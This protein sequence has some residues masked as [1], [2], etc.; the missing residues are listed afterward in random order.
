MERLINVTTGAPGN[1]AEW[2][3][4]GRPCVPLGAYIL[5]VVLGILAP[6]AGVSGIML[7]IMAVDPPLWVDPFFLLLFALSSGISA[8]LLGFLWPTVSWKWGIWL[9]LPFI[10][11]AALV[12]VAGPASNPSLL[13]MIAYSL[14]I[15]SPPTLAGAFA[16]QR[17]ARRV[18]STGKEREGQSSDAQPVSA[19]PQQATNLPG[20][21]WP[22]T[23]LDREVE[24]TFLTER[25]FVAGQQVT[26][27]PFDD[28]PETRANNDSRKE[29]D[30]IPTQDQLFELFSQFQSP[31]PKH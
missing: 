29:A 21:G 10:L 28:I 11:I 30:Y 22:D 27:K 1:G 13:G 2:A 19:S 14:I 24:G 8:V 5:A 12:N 4:N 9:S 3:D 25:T 26:D 17:C 6:C 15:V 16:G 20:F 7:A 23:Q 31:F 18:Q